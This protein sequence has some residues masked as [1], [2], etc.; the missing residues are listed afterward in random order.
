MNLPNS[1]NDSA[2]SSE[3]CLDDNDSTME[4][5]PLHQ[6]TPDPMFSCKNICSKSK[7]SSLSNISCIEEVDFNDLGVCL[8]YQNNPNYKTENSFYSTRPVLASKLLINDTTDQI[9]AIVSAIKKYHQSTVMLPHLAFTPNRE[10]TK[11]CIIV[12]K[13]DGTTTT[14]I[15]SKKR[16]LYEEELIANQTPNGILVPYISC[17]EEDNEPSFCRLEVDISINILNYIYRRRVFIMK[18]QKNIIEETY[19][20]L[21]SI[22]KRGVMTLKSIINIGIH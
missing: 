19:F 2:F 5:Y 15:E 18:E 12:Y 17:K 8:T 7:S 3:V 11:N 20:L 6:N 13:I 16:K 21:E 14:E 10:V 22:L 1:C 9:P 4:L